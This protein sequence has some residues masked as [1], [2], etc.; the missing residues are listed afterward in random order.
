MWAAGTYVWQ[1]C[2][3]RVWFQPKPCKIKVTMAPFTDPPV[4]SLYTYHLW[5]CIRPVSRVEG[6]VYR[7]NH[8]TGTWFDLPDIQ[9]MCQQH[10]LD[11]PAVWKCTIWKGQKGFLFKGLRKR[12]T[13]A[14][15]IV[16]VALITI[17]VIVISARY[18][19][20]KKKDSSY[21][22]GTG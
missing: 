8:E 13:V 18:L 16:S 2:S 7:Q 22:Y 1:S 14:V 11:T 3:V 15:T 20:F 9:N 12:V 17:T 6:V 21:P 19:I 5:G 4:L 10:V